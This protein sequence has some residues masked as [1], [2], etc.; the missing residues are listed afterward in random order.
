MALK[1]TEENT[2]TMVYQWPKGITYYVT[3]FKTG[4]LRISMTYISQWKIISWDLKYH[5][6]VICTVNQMTSFFIKCN[7]PMKW[8]KSKATEYFKLN[9]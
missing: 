2:L 1:E 7:T 5:Y 9:Y 4:K 8:V 3:T 6:K